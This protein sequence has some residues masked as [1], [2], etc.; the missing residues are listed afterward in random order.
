MKER[1]IFKN[2]DYLSIHNKY[3][4]FKN[5]N[6]EFEKIYKTIKDE[7]IK[8]IENNEFNITLERI[9]LK[10][11]LSNYNGETLNYWFKIM[12]IVITI[13]STAY[14]N[15]YILKNNVNPISVISMFGVMFII[16]MVLNRKNIRSE[17]R[18][19]QYYNACLEVLDELEKIK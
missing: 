8:R 4:D 6:A 3:K 16:T 14:L 18:S 15:Q 9:Y 1:H 2:E 11:K 12:Y 13:C 5:K 7:Y 19:Y 10:R 17:I